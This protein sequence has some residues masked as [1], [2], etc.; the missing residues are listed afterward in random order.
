M[1]RIVVAVVALVAALASSHALATQ[2]P[3]KEYI[4]EAIA[5]LDLTPD[6]AEQLT[7]VLQKSRAEQ[8]AIFASYGVDPEAANGP[9][10]NLGFQT[11]RAMKK[12]LDAVREATLTVVEKI[13]T[14]EQFKEFKLIQEER[15]REMRNRLRG[16][17]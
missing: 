10:E 3:S 16:R 1:F 11:M 14:D 2:E 13:L 4:E 12:E 5:R 17:R 9:P 15:S 6:Q 8:Q 7:P